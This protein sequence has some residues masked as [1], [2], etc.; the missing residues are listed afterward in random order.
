MLNVKHF[1]VGC[2]AAD[3]GNLIFM[4]VLQEDLRG[5]CQQI[6]LARLG[7]HNDWQIGKTKI[8]LKVVLYFCM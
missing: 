8:F 5:T 4:I 6:V 2:R 1:N 3:K 7:K